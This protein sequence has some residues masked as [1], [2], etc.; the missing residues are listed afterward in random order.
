MD[1]AGDQERKLVLKIIVFL[2]CGMFLF[3]SNVYAF[4][5]CNPKAFG[6][7]ECPYDVTQFF[8]DLEACHKGEQ[9]PA[10]KT[11]GCDY[12]DMMRKYH[13]EE[14]MVQL[15][16]AGMDKI[17]GPNTKFDTTCK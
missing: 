15:I 2:S 11:L 14:K 10:C 8:N 9:K 13:G 7:D 3:S 4:D 6:Y 16:H 12:D 1:G 17:I 5:K